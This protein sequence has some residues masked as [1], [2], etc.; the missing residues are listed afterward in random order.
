MNLEIKLGS[1]PEKAFGVLNA[2][3]QILD[4]S[5]S[6]VGEI[7]D[8]PKAPA[9][10]KHRLNP[11]N[12]IFLEAAKRG[13]HEYP[14]LR[15][16]MHNLGR[17][18]VGDTSR[19]DLVL[20]DTARTNDGVPYLG[21]INYQ[22]GMDL[23]LASSYTPLNLRLF[24][25]FLREV[26]EGAYYEDRRVFDAKGKII[27]S[28]RLKVIDDEMTGVRDSY[29]GRWFSDRYQQREDGMYVSFYKINQDGKPELITEKLDE[30][31]LMKDRI[32]GIDI[33]SWI[34]NPT[35]QGLPRKNTK[36]G[37]LY[38]RYPRN[39]FVA[40]FVANSVGVDLSCLRNPQD[41]YAALGVQ[42]CAEGARFEN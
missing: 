2:L 8:S 9:Q 22:Q 42:F 21:K 31:T 34:K 38:W 15:I 29:R 37:N 36:K 3:A 27:N 1:D 25:D 18:Y 12:F 32:P 6:E 41:S 35:A 20:K 13:N 23:L 14:D 4:Y 16:S 5:I 28:E 17:S 30:D 11:E 33:N 40:G 39:G 19:L 7:A 10:E 26:R 24:A